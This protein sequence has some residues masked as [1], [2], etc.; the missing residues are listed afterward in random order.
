MT[1]W[2]LS[3]S[4]LLNFYLFSN[5]GSD[6]TLVAIIMPASKPVAD[7]L[8]LNAWGERVTVAKEFADL[9]LGLFT[10]LQPRFLRSSMRDCKC[11]FDFWAHP[12]KEG[13]K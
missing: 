12:N 6:G 2:L 5:S 7:E 8:C 9:N 11:M 10:D 3:I 1:N 4:I 13:N